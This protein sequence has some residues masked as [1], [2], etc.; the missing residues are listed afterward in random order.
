[1]QPGGIAASYT[2]YETEHSS[3]SQNADIPGDRVTP[4]SRAMFKRARNLASVGFILYLLS[5]VLGSFYDFILNDAIRSASIDAIRSYAWLSAV[6][7]FASFAA[8]ALLIASLMFVIRGLLDDTDLKRSGRILYQT[9]ASMKWVAMAALILFIVSLPL[10]VLGVFIW[11]PIL[12][13]AYA[14]GAAFLL[15]W[16]LVVMIARRLSADLSK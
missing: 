15:L 3:D 6:G 2:P 11:M 7:S 10:S 13:S 14:S 4:E 12:L 8:L 5:F 9:I 16:S 1:M